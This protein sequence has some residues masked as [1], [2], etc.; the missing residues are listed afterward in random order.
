MPWITRFETNGDTDPTFNA[1]SSTPDGSVSALS[2]R[3][4]GDVLVGGGFV[5][6]MAPRNGIVR[7]N[8][9]GTTDMS[10]DPGSGANEGVRT[11]LEQPDGQVLIGGGFTT[12]NGTPINR[13]ARLEPDGGVDPGL[14]SVRAFPT[15]SSRTAPVPWEFALRT[16]GRI[17]VAGEFTDFNGIPRGGLTQLLS[18]GGLDPS[19]N[20][21]IGF[22]GQPYAY[23]LSVLGNDQVIVGG[24]FT[25]YQSLGISPR[26]V[27][28]NADA[29]LDATFNAGTGAN[30]GV[31]GLALQPDGKVLLGGDFPG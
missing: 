21:G 25:S 10:F 12:C 4:D 27:R 26:M 3:A 11:I 2:L 18:N 28:L 31:T 22:Q 8:G 23:T 7:L 30:A 17:L 1:S 24:Y 9:D 6:S 16:D 13:L 20:V 14:V 5:S 29:S 15:H 19:F